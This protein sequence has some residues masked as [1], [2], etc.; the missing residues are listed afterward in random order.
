MVYDDLENRVRYSLFSME[1]DVRHKFSNSEKIPAI[2]FSGLTTLEGEGI[3]F[4]N[5]YFIFGHE[6]GDKHWD[7]WLNS[8]VVE[9]AR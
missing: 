5:E 9:L 6:T 7:V 4:R 8:W 1:G 3:M 2:L